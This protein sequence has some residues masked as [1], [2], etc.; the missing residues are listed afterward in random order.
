MR[1]RGANGL[2][3]AA[4]AITTNNPFQFSLGELADGIGWQHLALSLVQRFAIALV[5]PCSHDIKFHVKHFLSSLN[6]SIF[7]A[8][9]CPQNRYPYVQAVMPVPKRNDLLRN[10]EKRAYKK[11]LLWECLALDLAAHELCVVRSRARH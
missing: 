8:T 7:M 5:F 2:S 11:T 6:F 3:A 1:N 9:A 10:K 4:A